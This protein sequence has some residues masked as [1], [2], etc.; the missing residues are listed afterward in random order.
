[1]KIVLYLMTINKSKFDVIFSTTRKNHIAWHWERR[2]SDLKSSC[3]SSDAS[4]A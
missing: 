2:N 3:R 1:M 4:V